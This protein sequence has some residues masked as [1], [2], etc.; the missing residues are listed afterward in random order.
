MTTC[1]HC[2]RPIEG[3]LHA[4]GHYKGKR[5][6]DPKDSGLSYGYEAEAEGT[7]CGRSC[8]GS[9]HMS[10]GFERAQG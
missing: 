5:R 2:H 4:G 8:L 1:K 9:A 6:C 7:P 10:P 3:D